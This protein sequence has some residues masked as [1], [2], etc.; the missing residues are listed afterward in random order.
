[1]RGYIFYFHFHFKPLKNTRE[2]LFTF[3][4][5]QIATLDSFQIQSH[6]KK[7]KYIY[8]PFFFFF[9]VFCFD[10]YFLFFSLNIYPLKLIS[11]FLSFQRIN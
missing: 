3:N 7:K 6:K 10:F 4:F 5:T 1:M 8:F 2:E 9:F 11:H